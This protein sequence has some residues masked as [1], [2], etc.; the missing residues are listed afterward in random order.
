LSGEFELKAQI[1]VTHFQRKRPPSFFSVENLFETIRSALPEDIRVCVCLNS[2]ASKGLWRRLY[3]LLRT[4]NYQGAV[5]HVTGDVHYLTYLL[6]PERTVLTI[7]D[8]VTLEKSS[9]LKRWVFWFLWYWLPEKRCASI[10]VI[11][12]ST[13]KE[14]LRYLDCNPNKITVIHC[15]VSDEFSSKE[16]VFNMKCPRILQVG[17]TPNKNILRVAES[18]NGLPCRLSIIGP[19]SADQQ[20]ALQRYAIDYESH[21]GLSGSEVVAQ[22]EQSDLVMFV[23][24]YEGFGLPIVEAN[25]VG[26]PVITS[27]LYSM[28]EVGGEAACYV[29]PYNVCEIRSAVERLV[30]DPIYRNDLV[31]KGYHNVERFRPAAIA[32]QYAA[33]YRSLV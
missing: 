13:K 29:D 8:C 16:K 6:D 7:L 5:N 12:Q 28:P 22:Y 23:S 26:R 2:F 10:T 4:R 33:L 15:S 30:Q 11:S 3:D 24:L 19:I 14:L 17:T 1:R 9:G 27:R 32:A 21:V 25:A 31:A 18:L 20:A